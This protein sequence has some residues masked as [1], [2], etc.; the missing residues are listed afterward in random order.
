[1]NVAIDYGPSP[2]CKLPCNYHSHCYTIA[3]LCGIQPIS[4]L[5]Q[6]FQATVHPRREASVGFDPGP[7]PFIY[8][9]IRYINTYE[10]P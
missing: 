9:N 10:I 5:M 1:M 7:F 8:S 2:L 6:A 3:V 4:L